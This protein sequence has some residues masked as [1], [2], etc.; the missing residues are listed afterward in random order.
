M[1][2]AKMRLLTE[3]VDSSLQYYVA[4]CHAHDMAAA[5]Y[6]CFGTDNGAQGGLSSALASCPDQT[7]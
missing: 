3:E 7:H 6:R 5:S 4:Y 2:T 1:L